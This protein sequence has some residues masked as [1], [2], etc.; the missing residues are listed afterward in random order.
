MGNCANCCGK[1][2]IGEI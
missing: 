1:S 2:D